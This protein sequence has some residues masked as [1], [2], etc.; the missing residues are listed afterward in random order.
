MKLQITHHFILKIIFT[1]ICI[2]FFIAEMAAW[3]YVI[4]IS[5]T[6]ASKSPED[7]GLKLC[8]VLKYKGFIP[9]I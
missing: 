6:A 2:F 8:A 1:I 3:I 9:Y 5:E 4:S 7:Q